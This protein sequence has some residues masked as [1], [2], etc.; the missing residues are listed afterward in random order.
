MSAIGS[1]SQSGLLYASRCL[2]TSADNVANMETDGFE[3]Q[4]ELAIDKVQGGRPAGV[5]SVTAPTGTPHAVIQRGDAEVLASNTDLISETAEQMGAVQA[6]RANLQA[7][8]ADEE[9]TRSLL[10]IKA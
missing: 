10:D 4:R 1:I 5:D 2:S 8:R 7:F 9:M 6:F 3:A